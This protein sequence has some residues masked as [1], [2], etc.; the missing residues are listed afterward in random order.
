MQH[1]SAPE[2]LVGR[3]ARIYDWPLPGIFAMFRRQIPV[4]RI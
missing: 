1:A 3:P 4:S 2:R